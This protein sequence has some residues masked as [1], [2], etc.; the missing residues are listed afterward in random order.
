MSKVGAGAP[1]RDSATKHP[2]ISTTD[3]ISSSSGAGSAIG[4]GR[5]RDCGG[6]AELQGPSVRWAPFVD[7]GPPLDATGASHEESLVQGASRGMSSEGL[8]SST[9]GRIDCVLL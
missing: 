8:F 1:E 6:R 5:S 4:F 9:P 2:R 3:F 7:G